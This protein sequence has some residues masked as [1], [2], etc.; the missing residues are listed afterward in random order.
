MMDKKEKV[1]TLRLSSIGKRGIARIID[2][3]II[4]PLFTWLFSFGTGYFSRAS[5]DSFGIPFFGDL[6]ITFFP[7]LVTIGYEVYFLSTS[8]Q[9]IGKKLFG[10]VVVSEEGK[11]INSTR[12]FLRALLRSVPF[13]WLFCFFTPHKQCLHDLVAKTVVVDKK[14]PS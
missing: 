11:I 9:T 2:L 4:Y 10:L 1:L 8:G 7:W 13:E 3:L 14:H 5:P 12:A 6:A